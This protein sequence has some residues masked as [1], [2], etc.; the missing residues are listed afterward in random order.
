MRSEPAV[1][2]SAMNAPL[3]VLGLALLVAGCSGQGDQGA[4][5]SAAVPSVVPTVAPTGSGRCPVPVSKPFAWPAP[6]PRDLP[7]PPGAILR[8]TTS[9]RG[10]TIVQFATRSSLREGVLFVVK[11]VPQAGYTLG[12]GDAEPTEADAPF[13][14]GDLQGIYK[15]RSFGGCDTTWL[16][17]V[18]S[19]RANRPF[20]PSASPG[21][22]SSPLPFGP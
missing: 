11:E 20:L 9:E 15:L 12:R 13:G 2:S 19:K 3:R 10:I 8:G 4:E 21:P 17:A 1:S 6:L 14:R 18:A 7:Q 16:V 22:G 5:P